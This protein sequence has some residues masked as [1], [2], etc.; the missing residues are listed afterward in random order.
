MTSSPDSRP[1]SSLLLK[2]IH[3]GL[4][5]LQMQSKALP[6]SREAS[7]SSSVP[8]ASRRDLIKVVRSFVEAE[9]GG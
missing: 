9:P 3:V 7:P 8:T 4:M 6:L 1:E 2:S 5:S